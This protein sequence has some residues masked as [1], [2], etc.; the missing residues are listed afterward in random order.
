MEW[1]K[2]A[3]ALEQKLAGQETLLGAVDKDIEMLALKLIS[4]NELS[5][6]TKAGYAQSGKASQANARWARINLDSI[7]TLKARSLG[8]EM[9][10]AKAWDMLG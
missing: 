10:C 6:A 2:L 7:R 1:K 4:S 9:V 5:K 8:A 3:H